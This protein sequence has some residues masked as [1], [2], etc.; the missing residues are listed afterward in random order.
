MCVVRDTGHQTQEGAKGID[1]NEEELGGKTAQPP[2]TAQITIARRQ[3]QCLREVGQSRIRRVGGAVTGIHQ[4]GGDLRDIMEVNDFVAVKGQ[5]LSG[6]EGHSSCPPPVPAPR[7]R[8]PPK[9]SAQG[10]FTLCT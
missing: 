1:P 7:S 6:L 4:V 9:P 5:L 2:G 8:P 10:Q 3:R